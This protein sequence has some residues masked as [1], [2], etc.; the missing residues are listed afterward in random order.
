MAQHKSLFELLDKGYIV[1]NNVYTNNMYQQT[2]D[3]NFLYQRKKVFQR[4]YS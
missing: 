1:N 3:S 2:I 4:V